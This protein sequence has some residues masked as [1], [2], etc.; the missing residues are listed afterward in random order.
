VTSALMQMALLIRSLARSKS[1]LT[2]AVV[3]GRIGVAVLQ[4]VVEAQRFGA[5]KSTPEQHM[6][7]KHALLPSPGRAATTHALW[8]ALV[9]G[10]IG[11]PVPQ[12]VAEASRHGNT[13]SLPQQHTAAKHAPTPSPSRVALIHVLWIALVIGVLGGPAPQPV[14]EAPRRGTTKSQPQGHM[15]GQHVPLPSPR[16]A[17]QITARCTA[18]AVGVLGAH[19]PLLAVEAPMN[20]TSK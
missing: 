13:K 6:A 14:G 12:L 11:L 7:G 4:P 2:I 10:T 17:P 3:S 18:K 20:G 8:I 5:T 19:V 1:V 16:R 9:L 15:A